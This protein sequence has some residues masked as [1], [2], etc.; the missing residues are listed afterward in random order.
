MAKRKRGPGGRKSK[1]PTRKAA[2]RPAAKQARSSSRPSGRSRGKTTLSTWLRAARST[3]LRAGSSTES[4]ATPSTSQ[5]AGAKH[6]ARRRPSTRH[7]RS[8]PPVQTPIPVDKQPRLDRVRRTLDDDVPK[9]P[10]S[11][12]LERQPSAARTGRAELAE[13]RREHATMTPAITG[14]DVDANVE[15]AYFSGEETP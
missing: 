9:P 15:S 7:A 8:K 4:A 3:P 13:S 12:D 5:K 10:S 11:L 14:G 6:A 2:R 1:A